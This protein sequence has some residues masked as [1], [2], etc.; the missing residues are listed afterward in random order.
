[1]RSEA[2]LM[3]W[4]MILGSDLFIDDG[5][6]IIQKFLSCSNSTNLTSLLKINIAHSP[7]LR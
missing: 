5:S 4:A 1:M 6:G 2:C 7:I 3:L